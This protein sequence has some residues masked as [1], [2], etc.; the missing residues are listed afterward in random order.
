MDIRKELVRH[1]RWLHQYG[2]NDAHSGNASVRER[3]CFW[4]TPTGACA[5]SLSVDDLI[6]CPLQGGCGEG[7]SLDASLHQRVY[8]R[9]SNAWAVLHSHGPNTVAITLDGADFEP[10]DFEGQYYFPH[11]PVVTIPYEHYVDEAPEQVSET[12]E[13]H[14]IMVVRG[15][16]VYACGETINLAYK[17]TCSLELSAK[18]MILAR[19]AGT[20]D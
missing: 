10:A 2:C 3:D 9:N 20:L 17:W 14:R 13:D 6:Q 4:V 16:G 5:D 12:L 18:T 19:L 7:A 8:Q 11:V 15:H 1:Y